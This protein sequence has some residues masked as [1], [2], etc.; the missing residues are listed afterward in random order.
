[1][2]V[3]FEGRKVLFVSAHRNGAVSRFEVLTCCREVDSVFFLFLGSTSRTKRGRVRSRSL[4]SR[5]Q[6]PR[7]IRG[8]R[9]TSLSVY[10]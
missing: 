3:S 2:N 8:D 9:H 7:E 1:M 5:S 4:H 10:R 6:K